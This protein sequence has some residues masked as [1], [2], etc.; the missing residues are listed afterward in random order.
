MT[1]NCSLPQFLCT[2]TIGD[3]R[4]V[5]A[6][7]CY[8]YP[9]HLL[10]LFFLYFTLSQ[11]CKIWCFATRQYIWWIQM[12]AM[13]WSRNSSEVTVHLDA[14]LLII[15]MN[16]SLRSTYFLLNCTC[17]VQCVAFISEIFHCNGI[18]SFQVLFSRF[19]FLINLSVVDRISQG[20]QC[21]HKKYR[22]LRRLNPLL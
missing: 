15:L 12:D 20:V 7:S 13:Q 11:S 3:D 21:G 9:E 1:Q 18:L 6:G 16:Y 10:Y 8:A 17:S 4:S 5:I 14:Y 2:N 19:L 22:S